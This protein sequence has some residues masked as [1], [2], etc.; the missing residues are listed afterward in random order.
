MTIPT[1]AEGSWAVLQRAAEAVDLRVRPAGVIRLAENDL[2]RLP[3]GVVARVA[4]AG[5][6]QAAAR[7]VA[8]TRWL[9]EMGVRAVRPLGVE[10]PVVALGR[11]VTFWEELPPHRPGTAADLAPLLRQLHELRPPDELPLGSLDPF[12]RLNE[13]LTSTLSIPDGDRRWLL[14]HLADLRFAW[15]ELPPGPISVVHGD[16]WG[17][18]CAVT[19]TCAAY[20][21]DFERTA[22]GRPE[23]DLTSTAVSI[24]TLSDISPES[25]TDYCTAYGYDVRTWSGYPTMRAIRELRMTTSAFQAADERPELH[26]E[27]MHRLA[28]LRGHGGPRP[29]MWR[30]LG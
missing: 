6:E 11:P 26:K 4:R 23:W 16:A 9:A 15:A 21:L 12:V 10:Q 20:L 24:D 2:W 7:E 3:D 25:Y 19:A 18:N 22:L 28:C 5:Q 1:R 29:W 17:G 8:V 13:R 30:S 27:A 14:A